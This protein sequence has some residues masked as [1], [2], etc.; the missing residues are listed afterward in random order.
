MPI[1][2]SSVCAALAPNIGMHAWRSYS[3]SVCIIASSGLLYS[4]CLHGGHG[5]F[6]L[7]KDVARPSDVSRYHTLEGVL[8]LGKVQACLRLTVPAA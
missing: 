7:K 3:S 1:W 6:R 4:K 8:Q 5:S 2:S